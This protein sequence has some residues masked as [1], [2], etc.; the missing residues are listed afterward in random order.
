[1]KLPSGRT[2]LALT[3]AATLM[4]GPVF[5]GDTRKDWLREEMPLPLVVRT[6]EDL[7]FKTAAERQYLIFNLLAGGR[8]AYDAG[9][10]AT[11][12]ERWGTL[13][14]MRTVPADVK[15]AVRPPGRG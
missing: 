8:I 3:A 2:A 11:A 1:M 7:S 5:A 12:A 15:A 9:D 4:T 6:P 13:L 14:R 10:M